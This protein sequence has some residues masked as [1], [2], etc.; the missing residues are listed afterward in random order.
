VRVKLLAA[1]N[2]ADF[3]TPD[4]RVER[5]KMASLV[6]RK[7]FFLGRAGNFQAGV[8]QFYVRQVLIICIALWNNL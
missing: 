1:D 7:C 8:D 3:I 5:M 2:F 4:L 6:R